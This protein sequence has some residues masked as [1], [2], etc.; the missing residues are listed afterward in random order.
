VSNERK[1][2]FKKGHPGCFAP[3]ITPDLLVKYEGLAKSAPEPIADAMRQLGAM[4]RK[5]LETPKSPLPAQ[6]VPMMAVK[7]G[8]TITACRCHPLPDAEVERIWDDV[9]WEDELNTMGERFDT[10]SPSA[11]KDLRDAAFHL[12][13]YGRELIRDREPMTLE[14][15]G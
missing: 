1:P 5:F 7:D 8:K 12:L 15:L 9:P 4:V 11:N 6:V 2:N 13:W 3:P 14:F 10:I